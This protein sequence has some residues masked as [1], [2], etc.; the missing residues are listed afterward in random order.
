MCV[1]VCLYTQFSV[2]VL[3]KHE[4][5]TINSEYAIHLYSKH[6]HE[7]QMT[8]L[9]ECA[10]EGLKFLFIVTAQML[11][12]WKRYKEYSIKHQ[13]WTNICYPVIVL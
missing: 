13:E 1:V 11:L 7:H 5:L 2:R 8:D 3:W 4:M 10:P 12:L 9:K 6:I